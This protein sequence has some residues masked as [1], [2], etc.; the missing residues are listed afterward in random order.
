LAIKL[1]PVVKDFEMVTLGNAVLKVFEG[2]V[3]KFDDLST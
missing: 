2:L 1:H 3:L